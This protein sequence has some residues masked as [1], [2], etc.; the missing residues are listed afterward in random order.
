MPTRFVP[1]IPTVQLVSVGNQT[2]TLSI[3]VPSDDTAKSVTGYQYNVNRGTAWKPCVIV[4]RTCSIGSLI[5]GTKSKLRIRGVNSNGFGVGSEFI[6]VISRTT[7]QAPKIK[8]VVT[9][10]RSLTIDYQ[11]P[12]DNGGSIPTGYEYSID[13]G[14]TWTLSTAKLVGPIQV[15]GLANATAYDVSVRAIN[16]AGIGLPSTIV[17]GKTPAVVANE[18]TIVGLVANQTSLTFD[19]RPPTDDGGAPVT[20]YAYSLDTGRTWKVLQVPSLDTRIAISNLAP[21][22][23]LGFRL[24][25]I[26]SAGKGAPSITQ[27]VRTLK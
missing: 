22:K 3:D 10:V 19:F 27:V 7:P 4:D 16:E 8:S 21:S 12:A 6:E 13:G 9:H 1:A 2:A 11:A 23:A 14:A 20:N 18:P 5:N 26:N 24:L 17:R 15:S 25:A